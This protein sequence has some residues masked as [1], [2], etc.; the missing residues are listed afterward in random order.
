MRGRG[1]VED[2][3]RTDRERVAEP[4]EKRGTKEPRRRTPNTRGGG[5][6]GNPGIRK[7][8]R[9]KSPRT[10]HGNNAR[11]ETKHKILSGYEASRNKAEEE[12]L[13][14]YKHERYMARD[15]MFGGI[16]R[17]AGCSER[18]AATRELCSVPIGRSNRALRLRERETRGVEVHSRE[19][20]DEGRKEIKK[21][22][23]GKNRSCRCRI[24]Q[25]RKEGRREE[26]LAG[27]VGKE[28]EKA[29]LPKMEVVAAGAKCV[30]DENNSGLEWAGASRCGKAMCKCLSG[31]S[32][33]RMS[34]NKEARSTRGGVSGP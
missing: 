10:H 4:R 12:D 3:Q 13:E 8:Q 25:R 6:D 15:M 5:A 34:K 20:E 16:F 32:G 7:I 24:R 29:A 19:E 30:R 18:G 1:Q 31:A 17:V 9:Y 22:K 28:G 33:R 27:S 14:K 26:R 11:H 23:N 2:V 21:Q